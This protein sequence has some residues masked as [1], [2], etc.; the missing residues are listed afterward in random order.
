MLLIG[1][2]HDPLNDT[3][4]QVL[5]D[6][7]LRVQSS[8]TAAPGSA[9]SGQVLVAVLPHTRLSWHAVRVPPVARAQRMAAVTGL[10]ED[11]WLQA[12][13][14]LHIS[15]FPIADAEPDGPNWWVCAC[16][17]NW[18]R[19]VLRPW[20]EAGRA[21]QRLIPEFAPAPSGESESLHW[22]GS[23]AQAQT[24]WCRA[25]GVLAAPAPPPWP[26]VLSTPLNARAEPVA[27][28]AARAFW[29]DIDTLQTQT[30]AER[31]LAA[32]ARDYDL[33]QG[34]W[35]Q[36][37]WQRRK[38]Q[39]MEAALNLW[40]HPDWRGAR[41]AMAALVLIQG[42]GLMSWAWLMSQEIRAQRAELQALLMQTFPQTQLVVDAPA[43]MQQ[44]LH[45]LRMGMGE[46][47]PGQ[48]EVMLSQLAASLS[49]AGD[50]RGIQFDG[51][52]L[53]LK[54]PAFSRWPAS[55]LSRLQQLGYVL[56]ATPEGVSMRWGQKP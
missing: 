1:L 35:S 37:P 44:N 12:P 23:G 3:C 46:P 51:Q 47:H 36:T 15:L 13:S 20:L 8:R 33:A 45:R 25:T 2:P 18:L 22:L 55:E 14:E 38:R 32:A 49:A 9:E 41:R 6:D 42:L 40:R 48:P 54:G 26:L 53:L 27:L 34:E 4:F 28:D 30:Q 11:L 31:W 39:L 21:P 16:D 52:T 50:V 7:G 56:Q 17:A 19:Q 43:Q 29:G 24:V 5:S 10:L